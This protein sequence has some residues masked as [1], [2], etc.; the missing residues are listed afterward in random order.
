MPMISRLHA[1]MPDQALRLA[2]KGIIAETAYGVL[3][4]C[5]GY[6]LGP[7]VIPFILGPTFASSVPVFQAMTLTLPFVAIKHA[8][9]LYLLIPMR[10]ERYY[11][12]ASVMNVFLMLASMV[13]LVPMSGAMGMVWSRIGAEFITT[14]FLIG[15]LY[16]IGLAQKI[17]IFSFAQK[18]WRRP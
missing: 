12:I 11:L 2:R 13:F 17:V 6:F 16:K 10:K 15:G 4:P 9:I 1:D 18:F 8:I 7:F 5:V 14:L 3:G